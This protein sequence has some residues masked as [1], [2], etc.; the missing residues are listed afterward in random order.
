MTEGSKPR[1]E[2]S[3]TLGEFIQVRRLA[4][5]LSQ[6][7]L[8]GQAEMHHSVLSRLESGEVAQVAPDILQR[9]ADVL[10]LDVTDLLR[11]LGVEPGLP[12]PRAYFRRKLGVNAK[13]ADVL[14]QLIEEHQAKTKKGGKP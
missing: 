7:Q 10:G 1:Q 8:A 12:E 3:T 2:Q 4:A 14:A 5:G 11:F 6:R 9:L 13:E